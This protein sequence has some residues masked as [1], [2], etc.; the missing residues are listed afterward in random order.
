MQERSKIFLTT[1][2]W[3]H[4]LKISRE[5]RE[6]HYVQSWQQQGFS[7]SMLDFSNFCLFDQGRQTRIFGASVAM[8]QIIVFDGYSILLSPETP[9]I[10]QIKHSI[11][12][13]N[14]YIFMW[15]LLPMNMQWHTVGQ[16]CQKGKEIS[17]P[18]ADKQQ[19]MGEHVENIKFS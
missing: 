18:L 19:K 1:E 11:L 2:G 15:E 5:L 10:N 4:V 9:I 13:R 7:I 8:L 14:T 17:C 16:D 3:V 12:V 6:F